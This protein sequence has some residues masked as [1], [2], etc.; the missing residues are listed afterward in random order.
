MVSVSIQVF[1]KV[2]G[3]FYR[4]STKEQA[5]KLGLSGWVRNEP[6]GSVMMEVHGNE[7]KVQKLVE[8]CS[9]GPILATVS[10]VETSNISTE[11]NPTGFLITA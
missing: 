6:D 8:W 9:K 3:V 7:E 10:K 1:G 11:I 5:D 4:A 2:Q